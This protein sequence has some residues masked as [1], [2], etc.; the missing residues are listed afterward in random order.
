M[1]CRPSSHIAL[2]SQ[3]GQM[4]VELATLIPV[5][6]VVALIG[7]NV[8]RFAQAC[9]LFD[10]VAREAVVSF[11]VSPPGEQS[12]ANAA[13]EVRGAIRTNLASDS[14]EVEVSSQLVRGETGGDGRTFAVS[15]LL[16]TYTCVLRYR[17][18][19]LSLSIGGVEGGVPAYLTHERT[20]TVDRFRPGVVV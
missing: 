15:P 11:G 10:R 18:W 9:P 13:Q 4:T 6:V 1:T 17:P 12:S 16:T 5:I 3:S 2:R 20:L 8:V 19:P 7:Y 14:S